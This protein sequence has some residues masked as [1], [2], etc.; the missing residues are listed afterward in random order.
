MTIPAFLITP[1]KNFQLFAGVGHLTA[2]LVV[3]PFLT[4]ALLRLVRGMSEASGQLA[5]W[6]ESFFSVGKIFFAS[7]SFFGAIL[8]TALLS[9]YFL[10]QAGLVKNPWE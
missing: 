7:I 5:T 1:D 3:V 2:W 8:G 10:A 4:A 9:V 6:Q